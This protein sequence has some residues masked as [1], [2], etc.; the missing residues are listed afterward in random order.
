MA[1]NSRPRFRRYQPGVSALG[2][3]RP[4]RTFIAA[5]VEYESESAEEWSNV[6]A[7]IADRLKNVYRGLYPTSTRGTELTLKLN[8]QAGEHNTL[9][10]R[11]AFSRGRTIGEVQGRIISPI[12]RRRGTASL[13]IIR[14][15]PTGCESSRL[16]SSK[17]GRA[18]V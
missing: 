8:H 7:G 18:H 16:P 17:I 1:A 10:A 11:Y 5:A 15:S 3:L 2:P 13:P 4:H 12:D 14:W 9:S 6:A